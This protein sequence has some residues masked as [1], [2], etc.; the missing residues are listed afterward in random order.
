M[1]LGAANGDES[2][3]KYRYF[4]EANE[5]KRT[6]KRMMCNYT[7]TNDRMKIDFE[8]SSGSPRFSWTVWKKWRNDCDLVGS[9]AKFFRLVRLF[10]RFRFFCLLYFFFGIFV[11]IILTFHTMNRWYN[12]QCVL[13]YFRAT[14]FS[15]LFYWICDGMNVGMKF[16]CFQW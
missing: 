1:S 12:V 4:N 9:R 16:V 8:F 3:R 7:Y 2:M 10:L 13:F 11:H 6:N 14:A 15:L 5:Q